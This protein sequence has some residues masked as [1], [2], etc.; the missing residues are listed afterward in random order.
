M[1]RGCTPTSLAV[2]VKMYDIYRHGLTLTAVGKLFDLSRSGVQKAFVRHGF[3]RRPKGGPRPKNSKPAEKPTIA[4]TPH[5]RPPPMWCGQ[6]ERRVSDIEAG[7][8]GSRFCK[9]GGQRQA[10]GLAIAGHEADKA[11]AADA[12]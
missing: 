12:R 1:P 7:R 9:A 6:C 10:L 2:T 4:Y 5:V 3:E 8:C 11:R